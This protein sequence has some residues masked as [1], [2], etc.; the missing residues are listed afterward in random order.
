MTPDPLRGHLDEIDARWRPLVDGP[1]QPDAIRIHPDYAADVVASVA[2]LRSVLDL[3][4][5][6]VTGDAWHAGYGRG[7]NDAIA[8]VGRLVAE[9]LGV[10]DDPR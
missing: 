7:W 6:A 8:T 4:D 10:T 2:A 5:Q 9:H 1:F 3:C